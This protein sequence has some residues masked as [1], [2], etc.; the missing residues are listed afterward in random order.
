MGYARVAQPRERP[1]TGY[2]CVAQPRE[3]PS[4]CIPAAANRPEQWSR[5]VQPIPHPDVAGRRMRRPYESSAGATARTHPRGSSR[6]SA[7]SRL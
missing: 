5:P 6:I 7:T 3:W 2:A 1:C 4:T